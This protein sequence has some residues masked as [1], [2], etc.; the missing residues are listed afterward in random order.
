[1]TPT[2]RRICFALTLLGLVAAALMTGL[3]ARHDGIAI[4]AHFAGMMQLQGM[5]DA[6]HGAAASDKDDK[7]E[8]CAVA[9]SPC[10]A[11]V[12]GDSPIGKA[13]ID[14]ATQIVETKRDR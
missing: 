5:P 9:A 6:D 1:M 11:P 14:L 13:L 10:V 8:R 2:S 7:I 12:G 3:R 4:K